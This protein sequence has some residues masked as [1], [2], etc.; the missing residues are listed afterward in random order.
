MKQIA[1]YGAGGHG[2]EVAWL[3]EECNAE[4]ARR[5]AT[6]C[7]IDDNPSHHGSILHSI[8][9]L[10]I[11]EARARFPE[12]FVV[13]G[14]GAPRV[15]QKLMERAAALGF[16][17]ETLIHP[18][19]RI[20]R[21]VTMGDGVM[22]CAGSVL[23]VDIDL[24]RHVQINIGCTVSHDAVLGDYATLSPGVHIP[25]AVHLGQRVFVGVGA[26]FVNG[27]PD[28]PLIVGDDAVI[29]AGACV[30]KSV[31]PG[32]TVVGVPARPLQKQV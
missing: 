32:V 6:V 14:I 1:I 25:G 26:T 13:G 31:P 16:C 20:S 2:R 28:Q 5:Y 11:E 22:I 27:A 7:F 12:A 10:G 21:H 19:V 15:R 17:F 4:Q 18:S 30:T 9:I 29:G 3:I 24:G 23:T 8:P